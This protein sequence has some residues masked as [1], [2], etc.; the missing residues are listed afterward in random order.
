MNVACLAACRDA[1]ARPASPP[2]GPLSSRARARATRPCWSRSRLPYWWPWTPRTPPVPLSGHTSRSRCAAHLHHAP[3]P[4]VLLSRHEQRR[5]M[6]YISRYLPYIHARRCVH[7]A[8]RRA[9][10]GRGARLLRGRHG[11]GLTP[12]GGPGGGGTVC[13]IQGA[14]ALNIRWHGVMCKVRLV[15]AA[16]RGT[17]ALCRGVQCAT[18]AVCLRT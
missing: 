14:P 8:R 3:H 12:V 5:V 4:I 2:P 11:R 7:A 6:L 9:G 18:G 15:A 17:H 16:V 13:A 1:K 10:A